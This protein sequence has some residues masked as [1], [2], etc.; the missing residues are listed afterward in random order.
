MEALL[1]VPSM[2]QGLSMAWHLVDIK[3]IYVVVLHPFIVVVDVVYLVAHLIM[4][5]I[6]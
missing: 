1:F 5:V 3:W 6:Y 4:K 2:G